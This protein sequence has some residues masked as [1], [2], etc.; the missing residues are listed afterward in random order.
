MSEPDFQLAVLNQMR[1]L[2]VGQAEIATD[3]AA[4][5]EH[6]K[7]LNGKVASHEK[8]LNE[9]RNQCP[10]VDLVEGRV[11]GL[12]DANTT[13]TAVEKTSSDWMKKI[14][15]FIWALCGAIAILILKNAPVFLKVIGG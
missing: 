6:L 15:P 2:A 12:E 14:W 9:R 8:E 13:R 7:T 11:R 1:D 5:K 4:V 10:L 3:M